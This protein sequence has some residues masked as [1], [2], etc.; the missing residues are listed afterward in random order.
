MPISEAHALAAELDLDLVEED[1]K[2]D[3]PLVRVCDYGK[4]IYEQEV[5]A[6]E[7]VREARRIIREA[8][9]TDPAPPGP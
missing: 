2:S 6:R 5:G 4:T 7:V 3:P 8:A 9:D 1:P